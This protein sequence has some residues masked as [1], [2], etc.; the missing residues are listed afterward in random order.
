MKVCHRKLY[1]KRPKSLKQS[2]GK[3]QNTMAIEQIG[4]HDLAAKGTSIKIPKKTT[5]NVIKINK[6]YQC[7]YA[8]SHAGILRRHLK[9]HSGEKSNKCN[10]CNFASAQASDLRRHLKIHGEKS[11]KCILSSRQFEETFENTQWR[12]VKQMQP[13]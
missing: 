1:P 9:T 8:S 11:N 3:E 2:F 4:N 6:C 5:D 12:K 10:Q 7:D 13:V